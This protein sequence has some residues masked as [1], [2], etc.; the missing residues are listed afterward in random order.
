LAQYSQKSISQAQRR[1][2]ELLESAPDPILELDNE[3]RIVLLNRMAEQLFGNNRS[4]LLG[5]IVEVLVPENVHGVH[6]WHRTQYLNPA[7][8]ESD[9][10]WSQ[11]G[12]ARK[13]GSHIPVEISLSPVKSETGFRIT[14]IIRDTTERRQ[15]EDQ[16]RVMQEKYIHELEVRHREAERANQL[17]TQFL[18]T[19]SHKLR[20]PLHT[21]IWFP[22]LLAEETE[23]SLNEKQKRF[24]SHIH[25]DSLQLLH[26]IN[27][28]RDLSKS[29]AGRFELRHEA[30]HVEAVIQETSFV[31]LRATEK[32]VGFIS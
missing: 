29:E 21:V 7:V 11:T 19:V 14:A 25:K 22:E 30:F 4:E 1:L 3:G 5:Q 6:K 16:L 18:A 28:L 12:G 8:N 2:G 9:W 27:D 31:W 20:S 15:M 26:L 23:D 32:S 17:K 10:L 13:D 24:I